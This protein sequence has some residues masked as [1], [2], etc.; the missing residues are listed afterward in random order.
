ME[1]IPIAIKIDQ[2][3]NIEH[4]SCKRITQLGIH[5]FLFVIFFIGP[6]YCVRSHILTCLVFE[7]A[8]SARGVH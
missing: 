8:L 6:P 2:N 4:F 1:D 3:I 7:V 5:L